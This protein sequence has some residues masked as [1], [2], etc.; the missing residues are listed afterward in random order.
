MVHARLPYESQIRINTVKP[1]LGVGL[2]FSSIAPAPARCKLCNSSGTVYVTL[3]CHTRVHVSVHAKG[4]LFTTLFTKILSRSHFLFTVHTR[5]HSCRVLSCRVLGWH[6]PAICSCSLCSCV[7]L[8]TS[9]AAPFLLCS[10]A[11]LVLPL[12]LPLQ[13]IPL[14]LCHS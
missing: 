14:H 4:H 3:L 9:A 6:V 13:L 8:C 11:P 2:S 12:L 10:C 7:L 1:P 5:V